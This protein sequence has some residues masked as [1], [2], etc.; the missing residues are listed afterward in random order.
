MLFNITDMQNSATR[1]NSAS[2][3]EYANI[4]IPEIARW[5]NLKDPK[6]DVDQNLIRRQKNRRTK[7]NT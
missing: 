7:S 3:Q 5:K 2:E 4:F 1:N 6:H